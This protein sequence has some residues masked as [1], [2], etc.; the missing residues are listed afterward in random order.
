[1]NLSS[2]VS[3]V[4]GAHG[5]TPLAIPGLASA[6]PAAPTQAIL[7]IKRK[8]TA[9]PLDALL[10]EPTWTGTKRLR[11]GAGPGPKVFRRTRTEA[12]NG[13]QVIVTQPMPGS[14]SSASSSLASVPPP[15]VTNQQNQASVVYRVTHAHS[16]RDKDG[17]T[18]VVD[19]R[20][21]TSPAATLTPHTH[22]DHVQPHAAAEP[23]IGST[24][25]DVPEIGDMDGFAAMLQEYIKVA[26]PDVAQALQADIDQLAPGR[27]TT[28]EEPVMQL[29]SSSDEDDDDDDMVYD[30]FVSAPDN[31]A[32]ASASP[33]YGANGNGGISAYS[34]SRVVA[35]MPMARLQY[36]ASVHGWD[37][38]G[39]LLNDGEGWDS[40][41]GANDG[42]DAD[43][44]A[45]DHFAN[46]YPDE[47]E[48]ILLRELGQALD[49]DLA[50]E[51][52]REEVYRD[53]DDSSD[54]EDADWRYWTKRTAPVKVKRTKGP[55]ESDSSVMGTTDDEGDSD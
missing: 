27:Y 44:N 19:V 50:S 17:T 5:G 10:L 28:P 53:R 1:M 45:E 41:G 4:T 31:A 15:P 33:G 42:V 26:D 14:S 3:T 43:S 54:D 11:R 13:E 49:E 38:E 21:T 7:R 20:T 40:D 39:L 30:V 23:S 32:A 55:W 12:S 16:H 34:G 22:R 52:E 2:H 25:T 36:D 48:E 35:E 8:R 6:A 9:E 51:E 29:D 24:M 37:L 47:D 46:D 18:V